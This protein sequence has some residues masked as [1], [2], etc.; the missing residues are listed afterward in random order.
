MSLLAAALSASAFGGA[1]DVP[2]MG[3]RGAAQADAF[4]AQAD[5]ATAIF[6]NPAGLTQLHGTNLSA[7]VTMFFPDWHF[8]GTSGA[9]QSMYLSSYLP[10]LYAESDFGLEN[11]RFGIGLNNPFGLNENW[12]S[13]GQ[14]SF[15]VTKAH[16]FTFNLAPTVAYRIND[17]LSIGVGLNIYWADLE[18]NRQVM[19]A[20][21][22][23]PLGQFHFHGH[24]TA[25]GVTPGL[26]WKI[27]QHNTVGV[28]YRSPFE[29]NF[30]GN[31]SVKTPGVPEVGPSQTSAN[32]KYPQQITVA[33]AL[34]PVEPLKLETD[35]EWTDWHV[36][37]QLTVTS[38]NPAFN[39]VLKSDWMS[40]FTFRF[41]AQY[42]LTSRLALRAGYAYGQNA[43]P[44][45]TFSP[46]VPDSNYN[47]FAAGIGY[48]ISQCLSV[49]AAYQYIYR[50]NRHISGNIY[51]PL[52]DGKWTNTF[53]TFVIS[54]NLTF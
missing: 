32:L 39:Q 6:Y 13:T 38:G 17:Q 36:V 33:Y 19:V 11:W 29:M 30:T 42:D 52:T 28:V 10:N 54:A 35:V 47:L 14:L 25:V 41:G 27:D 45:S 3:T 21:P 51:S 1:I 12:G 50:E 43:V 37:K 7:G 18:L 48:K 8:Q 44:A 31:A 26:L 53:N 23:T 24:D 5:D 34:R 49:D 16:L 15:L 9:S 22:P 4:S 40:G 2:Q 20:P 46:L